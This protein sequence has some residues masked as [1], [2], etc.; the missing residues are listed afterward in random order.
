MKILEENFNL[1]FEENKFL[2]NNT[3][4]GIFPFLLENLQNYFNKEKILVIVDTNEE[5]EEY[6]S[7]IKKISGKK[8][9][10]DFPSWDCLPYDEISPTKTVLNKRFKIFKLNIKDNKNSCTIFTTVD[11]LIQKVPLKKNIEDQILKFEASKSYN[12]SHISSELQNVG[13]KKVNLVLEPNEYALRG[14]IVD[15]WPLGNKEPFRLDFFGETLENIK[16]FDPVSQLSNKKFEYVLIEGPIEV[17]MHKKSIENFIINYRNLFGPVVN[18]DLFVH[19]IYNKNKLDGI[20]HLLP[21]FYNYK[22]ESIINL[23][24]PSI[25]VCK[26]NLL[27][28]IENKIEQIKKNY[29]DKFLSY[30][31]NKEDKNGPL[32]PGKLYLNLKQI[33]KNLENKKLVIINEIEENNDFNAYNIKSTDNLEFLDKKISREQVLEKIKKIIKQKLGYKKIIFCFNDKRSQKYIEEILNNFAKD[34]TRTTKKN[35][36]ECI[37]N[38]S[39][40]DLIDFPAEKGFETNLIKFI[41]VTDIISLRKSNKERKFKNNITDLSQLNIDD[42]V[43][44][45]DHG[46]GKYLGLKTISI[47]EKPHDCL[48]VE[49]L[50]ESKLYVPVEN[51]NLIS[52]YGSSLSMVELDKLGSSSWNRRKSL[53]KTKIRDLANSLITLAAKRNSHKARKMIINETKLEAFSKEFGYIETDDQVATLT[54]VYRDLSSQRLMDRLICGDVG[55]GK[56][57]IALRASFVIADNNLLTL[58]VVPSTLLAKQHYETFSK[59]FKNFFKVELITR[60]TSNKNKNKILE[61]FKKSIVKVV[62]ATH[63]IFSVDLSNFNLGLIIIDEEQHFGVA[64]KEKIKSFKTNVNVLT[65][66]A[67]PI[68]RTL[69]MSLIGVRELSLIKTPPVDRKSIKTYICKF[70]KSIIQRAINN[71]LDRQGQIFLIVPK[72]KDINDVAR[73]VISIFPKVR[74]GIAHGKLKTNDLELVMHKFYNYK[75]D[76]LISTSIVEA[77]LDIPR[78]NTLIVYKADYFGLAQLHQ[79]RG[80]IGRSNIKGFAYFS[81]EKNK[82]TENATRRLK[83]LKAMDKLGAGIN[84]ANYDLDIRGAGNLLGEEQSG[85]IIQVGIE[86]YQ[87]LLEECFNDLKDN[88]NSSSFNVEIN[89]K[90][91]ILIPEDYIPD[92]SLRLSMYRKLGEIRDLMEIDTYKA[93]VLNRFGKIPNE[94]SNLI[95]VMYLKILCSKA[96]IIKLNITDKKFYVFFNKNFK[97]YNDNFIR[98]ITSSK[99]NIV[100]N[101]SHNIQISHNFSEPKKQMLNIIELINKIINL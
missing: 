16:S 64:Q 1:Q 90:L 10:L 21:L 75:I 30:E 27:D 85:Q 15:I 4:K 38:T 60:F 28:I 40:I 78:A 22:L 29:N 100:L 52:K 45:R 65:L 56:T 80:R 42:Y 91:P 48:V 70:E 68:P 97:N 11:S 44:H 74:L 19:N 54:E 86:L 55:F 63:S 14:G 92:L 53:V 95:D 89:I 67:T 34:F 23:F 35:T 7:I 31:E 83:A 73:K 32:E 36:Y 82:I 13:Y 26:S 43:V 2:F 87:K 47:L 57:E 24:N 50:N 8:N 81:V 94:F 76:L 88:K 39:I 18:K 49:Y 84:L 51:I 58:I 61:D 6:I 37:D 17:P 12:I 77:G 66:S 5:I 69:Y 20:E 41:P 62:I 72:I 59:R 3:S 71:E 25:I 99:S 96:N 93:E 79:L 33:K 9:L 46:I 98:W 101:S